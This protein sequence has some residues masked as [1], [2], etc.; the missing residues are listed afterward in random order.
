MTAP[1]SD[2]P[3]DA[4]YIGSMGMGW[5]PG[6]AINIETGERLN[7]M[8]GEDS[9]LSAQNGRD[10]K[11]NPTE[12]D[13]DAI[14]QVLDPNIFSQVG[15][16]PL[17]GGKHYVYVMRHDNNV[18]NV[19]NIIFNFP[20]PAY[21]AG[22]Y[23]YS[24][25]DTIFQSI[26]PQTVSYFFS[27][28]MYV[29]MPMGIKGQDWLSNDAKIKIRVAKQYQQYFSIL[30]LDTVPAGMD[31]NKYLPKYA[32]ST[33][34]IASEMANPDKLQT[35]LDLINIVPNPYYA[36]SSYER[37]A[38]DN[39]V[40]ITN[41]PER[42]VVTIYNMSGVKVRQF[43]KDEPK[44]SIDWDLKNF[45][46]VPIASGIYLIHIKSEDGERIIKWFGTMRPIDLNTF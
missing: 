35:D 37:N 38:L 9:Y 26:I 16:D 2:N 12:K 14:S 29:G 18:F 23:A 19:G 30:P 4:N 34:G 13:M 22:H 20:S 42:C 25:L 21:D 36:Y 32:F 33:K 44:T 39:R 6:Y 43:K 46:G 3:N 1:P 27:Q 24:M 5:F 28:V 10:M 40:K 31:V 15:F 7:L 8:F 17:M 11:F 41:L 45:A